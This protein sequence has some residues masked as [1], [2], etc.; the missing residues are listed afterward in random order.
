MS[1]EAKPNI[2]GIELPGMWEEADFLDGDPDERSYSER[3][4]TND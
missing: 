1:N 2:R 4:T 3:E